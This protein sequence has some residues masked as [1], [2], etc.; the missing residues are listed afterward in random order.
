MLY[1]FYYLLLHYL[2]LILQLMLKVIYPQV[3]TI[4]LDNSNVKSSDLA[5]I[6]NMQISY[7]I[8]S[9]NNLTDYSEIKNNSYMSLDNN[10]IIKKKK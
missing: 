6:S 7:L 9:N 1:Y 8:L 2:H 10:N 5:Y 4:S 3:I